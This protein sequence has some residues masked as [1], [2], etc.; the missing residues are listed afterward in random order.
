MHL[1]TC[2]AEVEVTSI[3]YYYCQTK[4]AFFVVGIPLF[5]EKKQ[6]E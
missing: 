2:N 1:R 3:T 6:N 4:I 5:C